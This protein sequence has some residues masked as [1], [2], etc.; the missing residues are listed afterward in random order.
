MAVYVFY[1]VS[2]GRIQLLS[3]WN[4][5]ILSL[6]SFIFVVYFYKSSFSCLKHIKRP[7]IFLGE[8]SYSL[9]LM[10][11]FGYKI[12]LLFSLENKITI[13]L[14]SVVLSII[15]SWVFYTF[16]EK[17]F[18]ELCKKKVLPMIEINKRSL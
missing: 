2:G 3:G 13:F 18:V 15:I 7:L 6:C 4:R 14:L 9:Y 16:F 11:T 10:H 5:I 17:I 8:I 1:S 12:V